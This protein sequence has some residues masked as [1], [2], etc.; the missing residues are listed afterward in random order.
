[1]S[2]AII[3]LNQ[4]THTSIHYNIYEYKKKEEKKYLLLKNV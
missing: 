2:V 3:K 4:T 1:M